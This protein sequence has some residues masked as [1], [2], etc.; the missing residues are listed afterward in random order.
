MWRKC[1]HAHLK[2]FLQTS[3]HCLFVGIKTNP[4]AT[5]FFSVEN[6]Q[7]NPFTGFA[8]HHGAI[9]IQIKCYSQRMQIIET[10]T[11]HWNGC[12][13]KDIIVK[14]ANHCI[15]RKKNDSKNRWKKM[16]IP[17]KPTW[18]NNYFKYVGLTF[19]KWCII[20]SWLRILSAQRRTQQKL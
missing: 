16:K 2:H 13:E 17:D 1:S 7:F 20:F 9:S 3:V 6:D 4:N 8:F 11:S 5:I 18:L 15:H 10:K 19:D 12:T 14:M